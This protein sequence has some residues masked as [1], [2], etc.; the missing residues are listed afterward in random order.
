MPTP[1]FSCCVG[2]GG[3][4]VSPRVSAQGVHPHCML[5]Y[6]QPLHVNRMADRCKNITLPQTS[7]AGDNNMLASH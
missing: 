4:W 5:G 1:P 6:T 7:F 3:G 2:G